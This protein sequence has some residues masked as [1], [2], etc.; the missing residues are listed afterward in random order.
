VSAQI[1][2]NDILH[3]PANLNLMTTVC[4]RGDE[5]SLQFDPRERY[6]TTG[7]DLQSCLN[8][9]KRARMPRLQLRIVEAFA[10]RSQE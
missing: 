6:Y 9:R 2:T 7:I 4:F 8:L 1:F 3:I 10:L 5:F